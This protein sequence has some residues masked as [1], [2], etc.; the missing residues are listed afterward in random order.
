MPKCIWYVARREVEAPTTRH[1]HVRTTVPV[2]NEL[3]LVAE[4]YREGYSGNGQAIPSNRHVEDLVGRQPSLLQEIR[5][6]ASHWVPIERLDAIYHGSDEG[7][8]K[9]CSFEAG[10]IGR[11]VSKSAFDCCR[12]HHE[13]NVLVYIEVHVCSSG[14]CWRCETL[15]HLFSFVKPALAYKPPGRFWGEVDQWDEE[16]WPEPLH[17]ERNPVCPVVGDMQSPSEHTC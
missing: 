15:D 17:G 2:Q 16:G 10:D 13:G 1:I 12:H 8:T 6:K 14:D 11:L 7:S 4:T 9:I 5:R 3:L